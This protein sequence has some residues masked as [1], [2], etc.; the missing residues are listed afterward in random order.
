MSWDEQAQLAVNQ[1]VQQAP[2]PAM[3]K[4]RVRTELTN[5]AEETARAAGRN[6]VTAQDVLQGMLAK[7]PPAMR[8]QVEEAMKGGPEGL[9]KLQKKLRGKN[10]Q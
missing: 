10:Q 5:A 6:N 9:A 4:G 2:L 3:L 1:A 7:M 8:Q